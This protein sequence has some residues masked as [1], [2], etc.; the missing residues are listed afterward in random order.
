MLGGPLGKLLLL[1][2]VVV[3]VW[4][5]WKYVNRVNQV[6][7]EQRRRAPRRTAQAIEAEDMSKCA[8]CGTY[9]TGRPGSCGR[10]DCPF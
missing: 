8:V 1:I 9:V 7:A 6:R 3:A 10:S 5:G 2:A 4:Y